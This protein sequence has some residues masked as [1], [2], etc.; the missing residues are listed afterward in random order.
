MAEKDDPIFKMTGIFGSGSGDL[1][2]QWS[3]APWAMMS[4]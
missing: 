4:K 2:R 3:L 1:Q